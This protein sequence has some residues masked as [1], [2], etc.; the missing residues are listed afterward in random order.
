MKAY[1]N[2]TKIIATV[3][4][5]CNTKEKL[6]ELVKAGADIFR[7]NFS[8]GSHK[9]HLKVIK[10][11]REIN[12]EHNT[13]VAILQDLQG[14]KIRIGEIEKG[15]VVVEKG[16]EL[17]ITTENVK[18]N[19]E[20]ISTNYEAIVK[21]IKAGDTI[22]ID[23]G[24]I[25]LLAKRIEKQ[26]VY[27]EVIYGGPI[28]SKKG[29]NLPK[30]LV[31]IPSLTKKDTE[32]L[33]FGLEHEVDWIALSFVRSEIDILLLRHLIQQQGKSAKIISKIEKPQALDKIEE[34]IEVSDALM[35]ARGDLGVEISIEEVPLAQKMIVS[36][37]R[38]AGKPVI[39]ATQMM[40]SMIDNPRPT[41]AETN[42]I[43]NA[44]IDGADTLMLSGETAVGKYPE[45][46]LHTMSE[47][48]RI[49]EE[50]TRRIYHKNYELDKKS[51]SYYNDS[52]VAAACI[53]A[54]DTEAEA[55]VGMT[56][57]G[58]TAF[59]IASHRPQ[60]AIFIFTANRAIMNQLSLLWG[61]RVFYYDK[62]VST[63]QT[64][65]DI[66]NFL[67]QQNY[68]ETGDHIINLSSMPIQKKK[69]TNTIKLSEVE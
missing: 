39:I 4:P 17:I 61:V 13:H 11:I 52:V 9:E 20:R 5:A 47:T 10:M 44:V 31:S 22:L 49:A 25:E 36:K 64:F 30:T 19:A 53:L 63:D 54:K 40:E 3:G 66:A 46:V 55:I 48:I 1:F 67:K 69:R 24:K 68:L 21:D 51:E 58:Y 50:K 12:Q 14:P 34:I 26:N 28:R 35:V 29:I 57:S 33:M 38:R 59:R 6:L 23:D 32:D 37:S 42:D 62:F 7:L 45:R 16:Q 15:E 2:R 60:A 56:N 41:R 27:T 8:H 18:G 65:E 43:A